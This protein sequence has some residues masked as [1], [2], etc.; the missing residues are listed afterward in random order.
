MK[1]KKKGAIESEKLVNIIIAVVVLVIILIILLLTFMPYIIDWIKNLPGYQEQGDRET[2]ISESDVSA[3][4]KEACIGRIDGN[5]NYIFINTKTKIYLKGNKKDGELF[6]D[7]P[8][9][10]LFSLDFRNDFLIGRI[11]NYNIIISKEYLDTNSKEFRKQSDVLDINMFK[12][13]NGAKTRDIDNS[14]CK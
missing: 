12:L 9:Y 14:I 10:N 7:M 8:W 13:L 6:F 5:D 3:G 1:N 2:E 11:S 4:D